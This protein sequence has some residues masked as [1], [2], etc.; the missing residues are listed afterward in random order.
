MEIRDKDFAM[1]ISYPFIA[2]FD[3][4]NSLIYLPILMIRELQ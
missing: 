4:L 3:I 2:I 1:F